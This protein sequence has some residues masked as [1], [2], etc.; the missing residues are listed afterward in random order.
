MLGETSVFLDPLKAVGEVDAW[1]RLDGRNR[2]GQLVVRIISAENLLAADSNG[3]SDPFVQISCG[4]HKKKTQTK[5]RTRDPVWGE[6]FAFD[7]WT[8]KDKIELDVFDWDAVGNNDLLGRKT[9]SLTDIFVHGVAKSDAQCNQRVASKKGPGESSFK[10]TERYKLEGL[11]GTVFVDQEHTERVQGSI[12]I[13]MSYQSDPALL[14]KVGNLRLVMNYIC[15]AKSM[16]E[17]AEMEMAL[18]EGGK[19]VEGYD[20]FDETEYDTIESQ[21]TRA[22]GPRPKACLSKAKLTNTPVSFQLSDSSLD[23]QM[24]VFKSRGG[25]IASAMKTAHLSTQTRAPIILGPG[26]KKTAKT[27]HPPPKRA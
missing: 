23:A 11:N 3:F 16:K 25:Q 4:K 20:P 22:L 6:N 21:L 14:E 2:L 10:M 12:K 1:Y 9:V 19:D 24:S 5:M 15:P 8:I 7:I 27:P 13:E 26:V 17:A 18:V